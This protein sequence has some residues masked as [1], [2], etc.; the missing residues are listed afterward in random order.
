M[1]PRTKHE[2]LSILMVIALPVAMTAVFP[3][4]AIGFRARKTAAPAGVHA[5]FVLL[6]D[7]EE[8]AAL[9]SARASWRVSVSDIRAAEL[10]IETLPERPISAVLGFEDRAP[11]V[12]RKTFS[13]ELP[14]YKPSSAA[15]RGVK[16]SSSSA[17]LR[18]MPPFPKSE[19]LSAEGL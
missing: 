11:S 6:S 4:E 19:L 13:Y 16:M 3:Y 18:N 2:I 12:S 8:A 15:L 14:P 9:K 7:D 5:A 17:E 1:R 10:Q